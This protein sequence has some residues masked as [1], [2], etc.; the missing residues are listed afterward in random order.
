MSN[1]D[2]TQTSAPGR[3]SMDQLS[4]HIDRGWDL[5]HRGDFAG[6]QTSAEKSLEL[7]A[8]SPE[9]YNLL[10][11]ARA[12]LGDHENALEH[13]R[14][15]IA[16]DD[17]F[18]EAMLNAAEVLIHPLHDFEGAMDMVDNALDFAEGADELADA[19]LV[20]FDAY[21]HQGERDAALRVLGE[22][23][24]G[25]F[26][27]VRLD[28]LVGRAH[29]DVGQDTAALA[30]LE[31]AVDR[32]A[33]NAEA[34]HCLGSTLDALGRTQD[35]TLV[36]LRARELDAQAPRASWSLTPAAFE[37]L[38]REVVDGLPAELRDAIEGAL[39]VITDLP[40]PEM[41]AD[42]VDPR[43]G[44]LLDAT[45]PPPAPPRAGRM[46]VYQ[47]NVE[48]SCDGPE[49][50]ADELRHSIATELAGI[51]PALRAAAGLD[52]EPDVVEG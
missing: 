51:F 47:R 20:K 10:G 30:F 44:V 4:A 5:V 7:D 32:D 35:A 33:D 28:F 6:A 42:G 21:L 29:H 22:L 19:L 46:F 36:L 13:Y 34:F 48:R 50:L 31:R 17:T 2:G 11:Y 37:R 26:E 25:P 15:A 8:E 12:A 52:T 45:H 41:I 43:A 9:A 49:A 38:A 14:Y 16:L 39:V 40:G 1:D 27:S 18:I 23:P 3:G 24:A